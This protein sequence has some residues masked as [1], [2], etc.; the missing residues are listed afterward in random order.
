MSPRDGSGVYSTPPGTHGTPNTTI[1]SANYNSNVDDVAADLNTPR[2]IV[3]GGTGATTAAGALTALGA[4]AKA[5]DTMSGAL[6]IN[7]TLSANPIYLV[8][9]A[10][11]F[12]SDGINTLSRTDNSFFFQNAAGTANRFTVN[13]SGVV[14]PGISFFGSVFSSASCALRVGYAGAGGGMSFRPTSDPSNPM[15]FT[16]SVDTSVGNIATTATAT[17]Y[18]TVSDER[19]KEDLKSFDAGNI[20]DDTN[21][22]SFAWKNTGERSY[23][24]IAQQAIEVYPEAVTH[25]EANDWWGIDYGKYVPVL[26]QELKALRARVAA[27]EGGGLS[28]KP[29]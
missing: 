24:V 1:L 23:G 14:V 18:N 17:A 28:G 10:N 13:S 7:N 11:Q 19:L 22:Y 6:I 25:T 2:P 4:V 12:L 8:S 3:A 9:S 21:V 15:I 20:I 26:L 5:G 27:L 29:A 16:N